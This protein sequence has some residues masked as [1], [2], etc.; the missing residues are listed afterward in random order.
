MKTTIILF[1]F[2]ALPMALTAQDTIFVKTGQVIP[3]VIVEK[4]NTEI[5]YKKFGQAEP[6]AIY[7]LFISDLKSI[8]YQ[9]GIIAD[10]TQAGQPAPDNKRS[11]PIENA[12]TMKAMKFSI[13]GAV[14]NF[15]RNSDDALLALW[16]N[17]LANPNATIEGNPLSFPVGFQFSAPLGYMQRN[18]FGGDLQFII[19]PS[20]AINATNNNGSYGIKLKTFYTNISM[21]YGRSLN[22]KN[23]LIAII[24]PGMDMG[25]TSGY[26]KLN[27]KSYNLYGNVGGGFHTALGVD[28][29]ISKRFT[30]SLKGG[31][32]SMKFKAMWED[33]TV[34]PV[35]FYNFIV[36]PPSEEIL[37]ITMKGTFISFGLKWSFY[38]RLT[39]QQIEE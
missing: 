9:D 37:Y 29:L 13:G 32:R 10:Y 8:H 1:L 14:E 21:F 35:K 17:R 11:A 20:D 30:A 3:A 12:G 6:A 25:F 28:W 26:I 34:D 22:H 33:R 31:Y 24:E 36:D 19:T 5:K 4:N 16:R 23:N 27:N 2:F 39:T 15:S 38:S 7:S 18:W